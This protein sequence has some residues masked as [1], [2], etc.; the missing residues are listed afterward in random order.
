M[1]GRR[2]NMGGKEHHK[3]GR[4]RGMGGRAVK[5]GQPC[6]PS[7]GDAVGRRTQAD[8]ETVTTNPRSARSCRPHAQTHT[9]P[10]VPIPRAQV[11]HMHARFH[12]R[13]PRVSTHPRMRPPKCGRSRL[14]GR[15]S[16]RDRATACRHAHNAPFHPVSAR[17]RWHRRKTSSAPC[18]AFGSTKRKRH[19]PPPSQTALPP[20]S[21]PPALEALENKIEQTSVAY[22]NFGQI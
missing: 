9:R 16:V 21:K 18:S 13:R 3:E 1:K 22:Y 11:S 7:R 2:R 15:P 10:S 17:S 5:G 19:T 20:L 4:M 6:E 12:V 8:A 14:Q